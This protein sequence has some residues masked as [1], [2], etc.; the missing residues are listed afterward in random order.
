MEQLRDH[1]DRGS[2]CHCPSNQ[3]HAPWMR[4]GAA[5]TPRACCHGPLLRQDSAHVR[6]AARRRVCGDRPCAGRS[7]FCP[8]V[9]SLRHQPWRTR[10]S[11]CDCSPAPFVA[12]ERWC[13]RLSPRRLTT[14]LDDAG[15]RKEA[16]DSVDLRYLDALRFAYRPPQH[17]SRVPPRVDQQRRLQDVIPKPTTPS[18]NTFP[19]ASPSPHTL[20]SH[21]L[22]L[23]LRCPLPSSRTNTCHS[24][25]APA[26][27]RV[28]GVSAE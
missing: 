18:P 10:L 27:R 22:P 12:H 6:A 20:P 11:A 1:R 9:L 15:V 14:S 25:T 26:G 21:V 16:A 8:C 4:R 13:S 19:A 23:F 24:R 7:E 17:V 28:C 2:F 5:R 3:H